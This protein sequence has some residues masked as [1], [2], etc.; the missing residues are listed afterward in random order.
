MDLNGIKEICAEP[1]NDGTFY[2]KV[3]MK[4][5]DSEH[6][7]GKGTYKLHKECVVEIPMAK[8]EIEAL[9]SK[10]VGEF[11]RFTINK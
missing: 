4:C 1:N 3:I 2:V 9:P 5:A 8:V 7:I 10:N 11:L 6:Q